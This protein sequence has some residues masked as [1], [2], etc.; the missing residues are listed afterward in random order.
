MGG[1][2]QK[3]SNQGQLLKRAM[4]AS[5]LV[6]GFLVFWMLNVTSPLNIGPA[7][8]LGVFLL[9][10]VFSLSVF[11]LAIGL[12]VKLLP[13]IGVRAKLELKKVYYLA[14]I[15]AFLPVF[16]LA[17]NSIGQLS[18]VDVILVCGFVLVAGFYIVRRTE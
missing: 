9:F 14:T 15:V 17:L 5:P 3:Q 7:G 8:I 2:D 12:V 4:Y 18:I 10:Y 1:E 16:L 11:F 13:R 6:L